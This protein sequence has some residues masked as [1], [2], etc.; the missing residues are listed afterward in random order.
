MNALGGVGKQTVSMGGVFEIF[1]IVAPCRGDGGRSFGC[2]LLFGSFFWHNIGDGSRVSL[3]FD[4]WFPNGPLSTIV[5]TRDMFCG[6]FT[7]LS[8]VRDAIRNGSWLWPHEWTVKYPLLNNISVPVL[9]AGK[10]DRL[11]WRDGAGAGQQV[12]IQVI[13]NS[14]RSRDVKVPW[15]EFVWFRN[16]IPRHAVNLWLIIKRRLKTQDLLRSWDVAAGIGT[17]CPLCETQPDSHEHLFF[18][19]L[20][21]Q[22]V[23]SHL[24]RYAGMRSAGLSMQSIISYLIPL[25][26]SSS[27]RGG[28]RCA[29]MYIAEKEE[30]ACE[31]VVA[32]DCSRLLVVGVNTSYL[33]EKAFQ[34]QVVEK[35]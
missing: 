35:A 20:F 4:R 26:K 8:T 27:I 2:V 31:V 17:V 16:Y 21:S 1:P 32:C 15:F 5:S 29:D 7:L 19:R 14:I 23:W 12:S 13:W 11:E 34:Q 22:Q 18:T 30:E 6:G 10:R 24:N 28:F 33:I 9:V 25:A 3:W